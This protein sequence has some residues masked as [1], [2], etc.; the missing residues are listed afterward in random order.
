MLG[1]AEPV[2]VHQF[3]EPWQ[4]GPERRFALGGDRPPRPGHGRAGVPDDRRQARNP[5]FPLP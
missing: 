1:V 4:S 5:A 2:L 3:V